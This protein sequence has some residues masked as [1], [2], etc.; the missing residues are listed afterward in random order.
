MPTE[1]RRHAITET[2][3]I[4]TALEFARRAWP[5]LAA[6]PGAL[7]RQLILVGRNTLEHEHAATDRERQQTI[8]ETSGAL[9]G[10]FGP[11]YLK[12]LRED[13]DE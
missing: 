2:D 6:K 8:D 13:W 1:H 5:E 4:S 10:I 9:T 3:D 12:E 7:L 11:N